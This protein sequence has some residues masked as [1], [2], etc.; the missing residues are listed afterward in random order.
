MNTGVSNMKESIDHDY[1]TGF[2]LF[3][4]LILAAIMFIL[5]QVYDK[6]NQKMGG[7]TRSSKSHVY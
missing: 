7:T 1:E 4:F 3:S 2:P 5:Y 6:I